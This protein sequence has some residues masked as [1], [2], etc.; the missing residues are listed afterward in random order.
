[1]EGPYLRPLIVLH[2]IDRDNA[3]VTDSVVVT[4]GNENIKHEVKRIYMIRWKQS[5][6][7]LQC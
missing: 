4:L 6:V 7:S 1:M 2:F 5:V 3:A